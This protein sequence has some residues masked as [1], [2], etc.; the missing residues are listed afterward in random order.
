MEVEKGYEE[1]AGIFQDAL[2]QAQKGKGKERHAK[3]DEPFVDQQILEI[4]RRQNNI[5]GPAFQAH[6]KAYEAEGMFSRGMLPEARREL[7][8]S[9]V[10]IGAMILRL[11][12]EIKKAII[13]TGIVDDEN[14]VY[15]TMSYGDLK[16]YDY[17]IDSIP[18]DEELSMEDTGL[19]EDDPLKK[20]KR[21][22]FLTGEGHLKNETDIITRDFFSFP[23]GEKNDP[24]K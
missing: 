20:K 19:R 15:D 5:S 2:D 9:M 18:G 14:I 10:Y 13:L 6:K 17:S 22:K 23:E 11:D 12:E 1:L 24:R 16:E 4:S 3:E 21:P 8:G 7:L